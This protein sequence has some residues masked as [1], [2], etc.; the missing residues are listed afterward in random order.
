VFDGGSWQ[1]VALKHSMLK[2][3]LF[4]GMTITHLNIEDSQ[5]RDNHFVDC[6]FQ[7]CDFSK[8][9][10]TGPTEFNNCRFDKMDLGFLANPNI[11]LD[12]F[13]RI[14]ADCTMPLS[15]RRR[16]QEQ[17]ISIGTPSAS[18]SDAQHL[19]RLIERG[20]NVTRLFGNHP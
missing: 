6:H 19:D 13:C 7:A 17:H 20:P 1:S 18:V 2:E 14:G 4:S 10:F 12:A 11:R 3:S 15:V 16:L 8:A 5:L 9:R